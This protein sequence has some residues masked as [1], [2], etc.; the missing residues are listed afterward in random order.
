ML[1]IGFEDLTFKFMSDYDVKRRTH[2]DYHGVTPGVVYGVRQYT[3]FGNRLIPNDFLKIGYTQSMHKRFRNFEQD[4]THCRC[5]FLIY[6]DKDYDWQLQKP[7]L[8]ELERQVHLLFDDHKVN[9]RH[10]FATEL[11]AITTQH[12]IDLFNLH[13]P[14]IRNYPSVTKMEIFEDGQNYQTHSFRSQVLS[15]TNTTFES[16]FE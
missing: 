16:F 5:E 6:T 15:H 9:P 4:G 8:I 3:C 2:L 14:A 10:T 12:S 1:G 11:F 13:L 7:M